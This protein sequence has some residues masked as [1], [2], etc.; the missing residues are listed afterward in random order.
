[1]KI[2]TR[3]VEAFLDSPGTCNVVLLHGD[4][5]GL[6]RERAERLTHAVVGNI[7]DPFRISDFDRESVGR[8]IEEMTSRSLVGG[9]RVVRVR[10]VTDSAL[11]AVSGVL[12]QT[13]EALLVLEAPSLTARSKLRGLLERA[14]DAVS[15][16]CFQLEG[17]TLEQVISTT[18][19]RYGVTV[20]NDAR[21]WLAG[22]LGVDQAVTRS[23]LGK[24]ALYV[25][26]G[27]R[28][29]LAAAQVSI[30]DAAGL[31]LDDALF[32]ATAGDVKE[33]DRALE[34][35]VAEGASPVGILRAGLYHLQ[36]LQ[37]GR[38]TM[39]AGA[40][41]SEA[42]R[43]VKPPV[44]YQRQGTFM[45]ALRV[46]TDEELQSACNRFWEAERACKRTGTPADT[47]CRS[48]VLGLAQRAAVARRHRALG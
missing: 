7:N 26:D 3:R 37:R 25:G 1:M 36:R 47:I 45:Q 46:W 28:V 31:S 13:N 29:D 34:L 9:R 2:E 10:D 5:V 42:A 8:I 30:G 32:A 6:I 48:A 11:S 39:I 20:E 16:G 24:L 4:D 23:E 21:A 18:L 27:G 33:A 22:Q 40:S 43:S 19:S 12:G 38:L 17:A 14:A 44:F 15:I 41:I 35:A